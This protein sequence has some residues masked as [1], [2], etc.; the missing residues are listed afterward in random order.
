MPQEKSVQLQDA[1]ISVTTLI[2]GSGPP[3]VYFHGYE[4]LIEWPAWLDFL[5]ERYSVH[6]P[7]MPGVGKSTGL[8]HVEDVHDLALFELD[9]LEAMG[10]EKAVLAGHDLGANIALEIAAHDSKPVEKLVLVAPTG[11]WLDDAPSPDFISGPARVMERNAWH[12]PDAAREKGLIPGPPADEDRARQ[13]MLERQK[14]LT[15]A[16]K[17]LWPL[18]DKGLRKRAHRIKAPTLFVWGTSDRLLPLQHGHAFQAL[19]AGSR[20]AIVE[21]AGHYP[22]LEQPEEFRRIVLDFLK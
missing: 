11:I 14:T 6:V 22:M 8:E 20:L 1:K 3:L 13:A 10:I 15:A 9:Y 7:L 19:V 5:T 16:G 18:P 17:F 2:E 4:G 21:E 12:D